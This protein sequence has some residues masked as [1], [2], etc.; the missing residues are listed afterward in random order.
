MWFCLFVLIWCATCFNGFY[1]KFKT[2]ASA[3]IVRALLD[4]AFFNRWSAFS[5]K[6]MKRTLKLYCIYL[7]PYTISGSVCFQECSPSSCWRNVECLVLSSVDIAFVLQLEPSK[8]LLL[9][10]SSAESS[11]SLLIENIYIVLYPRNKLLLQNIVMRELVV[12]QLLCQFLVS[13]QW[14]VP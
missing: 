2:C 12:V 8:C 4:T 14:S 1:L 13:H 3:Q 10:C 9:S 7:K 5:T 6:Q 11:H